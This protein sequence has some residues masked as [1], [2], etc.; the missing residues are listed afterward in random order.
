MILLPVHRQNQFFKIAEYLIM[1]FTFKTFKNPAVEVVIG[2]IDMV[3][4]ILPFGR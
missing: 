1:T 3:G 4:D 2:L